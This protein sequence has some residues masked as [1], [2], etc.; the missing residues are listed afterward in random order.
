MTP[1][2]DPQGWGRTDGLLIKQPVRAEAR[3]LFIGFRL[4]NV[5]PETTARFS[6]IDDRSRSQS[7]PCQG[8]NRRLPVRVERRPPVYR[9]EGDVRPVSVRLQDRQV[10]FSHGPTSAA[11]TLLGAFPASDLTH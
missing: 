4:F 11:A 7:P 2:P 5:V 1:V 3:R 10:L 8:T 6:R 9:D